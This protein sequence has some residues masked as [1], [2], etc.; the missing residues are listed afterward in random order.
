M[1]ADRLVRLGA[2]ALATATALY[3]TAVH[4]G[5][6]KGWQDANREQERLQR[7]IDRRVRRG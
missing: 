3:R 2:L 5:Y 4:Y 1:M 7:R 6:V